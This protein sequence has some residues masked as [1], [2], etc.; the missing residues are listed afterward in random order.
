LATAGQGG[1]G[2]CS[3][4]TGSRVFYAGG[5][6]GGVWQTGGPFGLG[7]SGGG[8]GGTALG[9]RGRDA[10]GNSGSGGGGHSMTNDSRIFGGGGSGGSGVVIIRYSASL[11]APTS[12][13]GSPQINYADGYQIYIFTSSGSITF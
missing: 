7:N 11:S 13:T 1:A 2:T 5:G 6:G 3:T 8:N 9:G 10:L 4:I 12:T